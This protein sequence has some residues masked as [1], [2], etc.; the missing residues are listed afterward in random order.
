MGPSKDKAIEENTIGSRR[1]YELIPAFM[2]YH[3]YCHQIVDGEELDQIYEGKAHK[4]MIENINTRKEKTA[5]W[6]IGR[7][8]QKVQID[9]ILSG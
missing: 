9:N 4:W 5:F 7:R 6:I 2:D 3:K 8:L 1:E